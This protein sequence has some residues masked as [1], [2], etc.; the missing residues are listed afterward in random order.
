MS[1]RKLI[2]QHP[3]KITTLPSNA[4]PRAALPSSP[5]ANQ[6]EH[7]PKS[8]QWAV[9][10]AL[11][12][13]LALIVLI[14][15]TKVCLH[16]PDLDDII[17]SFGAVIGFLMVSG[18][19][20]SASIHRDPDPKRFYVRRV[21]RIFPLA[22]AS[23]LITLIPLAL[24]GH[25]QTLPSGQVI[26]FPTAVGFIG[27]I[28]QLQGLLVPFNAFDAPL[29]SLSIECLFYLLAP[30]FKKSSLQVLFALIVLSCVAWIWHNFV[31]HTSIVEE[32]HGIGAV[33]LLWAW[34]AGFVYQRHK[35]SPLAIV[36]LIAP[37]VLLTVP[38]HTSGL[39]GGT[40]VVVVLSALTVLTA[41]QIKIPKKLSEITSYLGEIS[42]PLYI[43][44]W[45]ILL[46]MNGLFQSGHLR[47]HH[48]IFALVPCFLVS[49]VLYHAVDIPIRKRKYFAV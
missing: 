12:F 46:I 10:G 7:E 20:I 8:D 25:N 19:S 45:P 32:R 6:A 30:L 2:N 1:A 48:V 37:G 35:D 49:V 4:A 27:N 38:L 22:L 3:S 29:W 5:L 26:K 21:K 34:L 9:L 24:F 18:Y 17:G 41:T 33:C 47:T 44:H 15:H 14:C 36:A 28:F 13:V 39:Y 23:L 31:S 40:P 43:S 16:V 11:R 42:Y